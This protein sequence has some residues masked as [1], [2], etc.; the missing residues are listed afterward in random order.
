MSNTGYLSEL[1]TKTPSGYRWCLEF[2]DEVYRSKSTGFYDEVGWIR[3]FKESIS[4]SMPM[5]IAFG[6][7]IDAKD[8]NWTVLYNNCLEA[9]K[10]LEKNIKDETITF[11]HEKEPI[12]EREASTISKHDQ[13]KKVTRFYV[14]QLIEEAKRKI[15]DGDDRPHQIVSLQG[16]DLSGLDLSFIFIEDILIEKDLKKRRK[17]IRFEFNNSNLKDTDLSGN[18]F[19]GAEFNGAFLKNTNLSNSDISSTSFAGADLIGVNFSNSKIMLND[20]SGLNLSN[21]RFEKSTLLNE[22]L[23]NTQLS[24]ANLFECY[25]R[26]TQLDN[27]NLKNANLVKANISSA[28]ATRTIFSDADLSESD[29]SFSNFSEANLHNAILR[30]AQLVHTDFVGA[31]LSNCD[32][33]GADLLSTDF[34]GANLSGAIFHRV[35]RYSKVILDSSTT[36]PDGSRKGRFTKFKRFVT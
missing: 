33:T 2:F 26:G 6:G 8:I 20:L 30:D 25:L 24:N 10:N 19:W 7:K 13:L 3:V 17:T 32:L 23:Q 29:L 15:L 34:S 18:I 36:L 5:K 31:D 1:L 22:L 21:C 28:S 4:K 14:D 9:T 12:I 11:L 27:A 16:L 35:S